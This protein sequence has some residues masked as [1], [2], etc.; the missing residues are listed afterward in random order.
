MNSY[1]A[2]APKGASLRDKIAHIRMTVEER[3]M[4]KTQMMAAAGVSHVTYYS[5]IN[6]NTELPATVAVAWANILGVPVA[7]MLD[8]V[9][10]LPNP[11]LSNDEAM[12]QTTMEGGRHE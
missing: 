5:W 11:F 12:K 8:P 10:H 6:G 1:E 2:E 4:L 3:A 9:S 7:V